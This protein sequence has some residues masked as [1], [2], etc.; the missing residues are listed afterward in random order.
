MTMV[1]G[2]CTRV[3]YLA[4][5]VPIPI[6][7]NSGNPSPSPNPSPSRTPEVIGTGIAGDGLGPGLGSGLG[8]PEVP[9]SPYFLHLSPA[10]LRKESTSPAREITAYER[11][12]I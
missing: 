6:R 2:P 8:L 9:D 3:P 1:V 11:D 5:P 10:D 7:V 4:I 12:S